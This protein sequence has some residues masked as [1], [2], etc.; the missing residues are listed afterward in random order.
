MSFAHTSASIL[1]FFVDAMRNLPTPA[2]DK[3]NAS[4]NKVRRDPSQSI[5]AFVLSS[6][7]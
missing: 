1:S 5:R 6:G 3:F 2:E 4:Y 7:F